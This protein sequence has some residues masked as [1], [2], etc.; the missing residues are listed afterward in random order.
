VIDTWYRYPKPGETG[1][2]PSALPFHELGNVV[3]T[4][5]MSGWTTGTIRRRRATIA[6]NVNARVAGTPC[7]NVV[8]GEV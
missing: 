1:V 4:P 6:A 3:M 8:R 5:H 7:V 2:L